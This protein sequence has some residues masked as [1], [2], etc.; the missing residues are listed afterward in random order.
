MYRSSTTKIPKNT[1]AK[2]ISFPLLCLLVLIA[3]YR[4]AYDGSVDG[5]FDYIHEGDRLA[6]M[7]AI[8][9]GKLP[10]RD[11]YVQQGLGE[12]IIKPLLAFK[13]FGESVESLRRL[14]QNSYIYR[15]YLP[16][17]GLL[18]TLIA[19]AT[20]IRR[21]GLAIAVCVVLPG[22]LH[23]ISDRHI[24]GLLAVAC[25]G[26]YITKRKPRWLAAG[27]VLT[28][29]A[30]L[31]SLEVGLYVAA[32]GIAWAAIDSLLRF[33]SPRRFLGSVIRRWAWFAGGMVV[34]LTPFL[35]WCVWVGVL[36][37]FIH[38]VY[39]Q[40]VLRPLVFPTEYP[41]PTWNGQA[42]VLGNLLV[43]AMFALI[44]YGIPLMYLATLAALALRRGKWAGRVGRSR[45]ILTSLLGLA[46]WGTV[47]GRPD[48]WHVAYAFGPVV[49]FL[50]VWMEVLPGT[51]S[52][53]AARGVVC[54][55]SAAVIAA[56]VFLGQ[57]G[58]WGRFVWGQESTLLPEDLKR[59][60][61]QLVLCRGP[62]IGSV[63]MEPQQ[64]AFAAEMVSYIQKH[65]TPDETIL[66][67]SN[68]A[69]LYFLCERK[70]PTRFHLLAHVG[71]SPLVEEMTKEV[72][73]GERLP[74]YVLRLASDRRL[75]APLE[76][77][78]HR[79][80]EPEARIGFLELL[81]CRD[82]H[83]HRTRR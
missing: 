31:Y 70:S 34:G 75:P 51:A 46:F 26:L 27:G 50:A 49:V 40:L 30:G 16:P 65:T 41:S 72:L 7:G 13:F 17:L 36:R 53:R 55:F 14:G 62:R 33:R 37:D 47:V 79:Y 61:K 69:L 28:S 19:A 35:I 57:G 21:R 71:D 15:G 32:T 45:L 83:G 63:G 81:R 25:L 74:R 44:Y 80:Y 6:H 4:V 22:C 58:S 77:L 39:I 8:L 18:A 54:V 43:G 23:E 68:H 60:G 11:V 52:S 76:D 5:N 38:N 12:N 20:L 24:F 78:V 2:G 73:A 67:L 64:A 9:D 1:K 59:G 56:S 48:L 3:V 42:G 66:D 29:L 10:F 82:P